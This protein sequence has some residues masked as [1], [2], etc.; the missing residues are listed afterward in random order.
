VYQQWP[1]DGSLSYLVLEIDLLDDDRLPLKVVMNELLDPREFGAV[2]FRDEICWLVD[3]P[4]TAVRWWFRRLVIQRLLKG[5][6]RAAWDGRDM[7]RRR[8]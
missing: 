2:N 5:E 3:N 7:P 8:R 4:G 6:H 1:N